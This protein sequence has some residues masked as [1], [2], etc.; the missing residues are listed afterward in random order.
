MKLLS[1]NKVDEALIERIYWHDHSFIPM[2]TEL[3]APIEAPLR[4]AFLDLSAA[5]MTAARWNVV[6]EAVNRKV[7]NYEND[8]ASLKVGTHGYVLDIDP[9]KGSFVET[10]S[11]SM[12]KQFQQLLTKMRNQLMLLNQRVFKSGDN[13]GKDELIE[14]AYIR[15]GK[16]ILRHL[17]V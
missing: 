3:A 12:G 7:N 11:L 4:P 8:L 16:F 17:F 13:S 15:T 10:P 2:F 5:Q 9:K 14:S 1:F 6:A